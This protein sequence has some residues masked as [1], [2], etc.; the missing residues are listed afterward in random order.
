MANHNQPSITTNYLILLQQIKDAIADVAKLFDG[1][2]SSNIA[3]GTK[4][5]NSGA[6]KF[7]EWNGTAWA[8][9]TSTYNINVASANSALTAESATSATSAT[10]ANNASNLDGQTP[11]F[12]RNAG[13]LNAGI[14]PSARLP[15]HLNHAHQD[16]GDA[17]ASETID[18]ATGNSHRIVLDTNCTLTYANP[19]PAG[20]RYE[21][22]LIVVQGPVGSKYVLFPAGTLWAPYTSLSPYANSISILRI[23]TFDG[24][25][26]WFNRVIGKGWG[27]PE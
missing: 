25:A 24:G 17:G 1:T 22:E 9:L 26:T 3:V 20:I 14:I 16:H 15:S 4:R 2:T 18:L 11:A 5:W 23:F 13:N 7:E 8:D 27:P 6:Q 10:N 12:Y 21:F 19:P